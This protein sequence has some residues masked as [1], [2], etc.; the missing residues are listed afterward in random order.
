V[1][2]A[3]GGDAAIGA[4][5]AIDAAPRDGSPIADASIDQ[6]NPVTDGGFDSGFDSGPPR[7][8]YGSTNDGIYSLDLQS[9]VVHEIAKFSTCGVVSGTNNDLAVDSNGLVHVFTWSSGTYEFYALETDGGC[10]VVHGPGA[11]TPAPYTEW[12]AYQKGATTD[13]LV[14]LAANSSSIGL[15]GADTNN[16]VV[17]GSLPRNASSDLTCTPTICYTAL[18]SN[19][20]LNDAGMSDCLITFEPDGG[21]VQQIGTFGKTGVVGM[22]YDSGYVY[23]FFADGSVVQLSTTPGSAGQAF[24]YTKSGSSTLVWQ[25]AGSS[26]AK[27]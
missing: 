22:A 9:H 13:Y 17:V 20:C 1:L 24:D 23:G 11:S 3:N 27:E 4:D 5:S 26:S 10:G 6:T 8:V 12:E 7:V 16:G 21:S 19:N 15:S 25:G 2:T 14:D 18:T